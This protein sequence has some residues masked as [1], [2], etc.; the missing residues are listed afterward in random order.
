MGKKYTDFNDDNGK[1]LSYAHPHRM[2]FNGKS[3]LA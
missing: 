1:C 3:Q 2:I